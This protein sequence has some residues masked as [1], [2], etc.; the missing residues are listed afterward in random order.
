MEPPNV[1]QDFYSTEA[2][3]HTGHHL[4]PEATGS[5]WYSEY[6]TPSNGHPE[7]DPAAAVAY[8]IGHHLPPEVTWHLDSTPNTGLLEQN[9]I[10][11]GVINHTGHPCDTS[12]ST[13]P[14]NKVCSEERY[15]DM[16][17]MS[18]ESDDQGTELPRLYL[19]PYLV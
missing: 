18:S 8:H 9:P 11:T 5:R 7:F 10:A 19:K 2:T 13:N 12:P 1:T 4:S 3:F 17:P 16:E 6:T 15:Q 14:A